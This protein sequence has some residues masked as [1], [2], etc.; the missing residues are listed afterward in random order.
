M[1]H[2]ITASLQKKGFVLACCSMEDILLC[3]QEYIQANRQSGVLSRCIASTATPFA[4]HKQNRLI[5]PARSQWL[6]RLC[7]APSRGNPRQ[8]EQ[9]GHID[10][11]ISS[12]KSGYG[13]SFS[14]FFY[15]F[16]FLKY[17]L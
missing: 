14:G 5:K 4:L 6:K 13:F 9:N 8:T 12:I 7:V 16:P 11:I 15:F 3:Q 17:M 2:T 10:C 1:L